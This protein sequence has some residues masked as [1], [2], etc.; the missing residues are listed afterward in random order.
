MTILKKWRIHNCMHGE[1]LT[2]IVYGHHKIDDGKYVKTSPI[3]SVKNNYDYLILTTF[4]GT[5]YYLHK[6]DAAEDEDD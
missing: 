1:F 6:D 4:S 3:V 2:G 5:V